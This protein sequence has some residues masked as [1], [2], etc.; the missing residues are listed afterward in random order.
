MP[1]LKLSEWANV[2]EIIG[3]I[4]IVASL[5]YVG[6]GVNQN[7]KALQVDSHQGAI[8]MINDAQYILATDPEFHRLFS[9]G[10]TSPAELS[11]EEW[12][13]FTH[14]NYVRMGIWEYAYFGI[15]E[16]TIAPAIWSAFDPYFRGI[17]CMKG[18]RR[19]FDEQRHGHAPEF[20]A[21]LEADVFPDCAPE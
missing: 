13:R 2:A 17:V 20:V 1:N 10:E 21:Y 6:Y 15:Q 5:I 11:D 3:A 8:E 7:T 4:V 18:H 19:F 9:T 14:F 12:S 16:N